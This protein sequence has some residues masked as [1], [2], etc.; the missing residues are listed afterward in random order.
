MKLDFDKIWASNDS[1]ALIQKE[2]GHELFNIACELPEGSLIV[3][4]GSFEGKS[5][6]V[7]ASVADANGLR[8]ICVD[9]LVDF[10]NGG[11]PTTSKTREVFINNIVNVFK[12][13]TW[14]AKPTITAVE[15]VNEEIDY[16]F[17]DG[18]HTYNG[19]MVDCKL[20]LPKL[21]SG[22]LVTFHDHQNIAFWGVAKAVKEY[23][24]GWEQ[25]STVWNQATFRK[26]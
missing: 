25:F 24:V 12:N 6:S 4:V 13:V 21:K 26:P 10:P 11:V 18:D 19:V 23:C 20:W 15:E 9:P 7:L 5:S 14:I 22:G 17:I 16:M 3:E 8:L 2:E 1:K